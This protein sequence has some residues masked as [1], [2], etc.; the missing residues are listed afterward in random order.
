MDNDERAARDWLSNYTNHISGID[1]EKHIDLI[2]RLLDRPVTPKGSEVPDNVIEAMWE[3]Y[4]D[5]M[6][7]AGGMR[8][9][10]DVL[11]AHLT[12]PP[13]PAKVEAWAVQW[14]DG[15]HTV[16]T[17]QESASFAARNGNFRIV[18]LVEA[19]DE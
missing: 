2:L 9:V 3:A 11:H 15:T 10:I 6:T 4:I 12:A 18:R 16:Y 8:A 17:A 1:G 7:F 13:A 19:A 14:P 5:E